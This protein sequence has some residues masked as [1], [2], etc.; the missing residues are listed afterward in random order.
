MHLG[1]CLGRTV[2]SRS[3]LATD[4]DT[5][6]SSQAIN[7]TKEPCELV[8]EL[9]PPHL[10]AMPEALG[11]FLICISDSVTFGNWVID[12]KYRSFPLIVR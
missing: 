11:K 10:P 12:G 4:R 5:V 6:S 1:G 3:T 9:G 7:Q 2:C 8:S